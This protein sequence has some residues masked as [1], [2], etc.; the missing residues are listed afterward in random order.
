MP[1]GRC[2][3]TAPI[4]CP[5]SGWLIGWLGTVDSGRQRESRT[6]IVSAELATITAGITTKRNPAAA[7]KWYIANL[8]LD[9]WSPN[10]KYEFDA[11]VWA[12]AELEPRFARRFWHIRGRIS[13]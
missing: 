5:A 7:R 9:S 4:A 2:P 10:H 6:T 1:I 3:R 8:W 12:M 13:L 11:R